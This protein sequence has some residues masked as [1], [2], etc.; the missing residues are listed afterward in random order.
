MFGTG[1]EA[2]VLL[3]TIKCPRY[4]VLI[5]L[6]VSMRTA[7]VVN[8]KSKSKKPGNGFEQNPFF[9]QYGCPRR[10]YL[11][12]ANIFCRLQEG[13]YLIELQATCYA[14]YRR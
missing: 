2:A 9:K 4:L 14:T 1:Q 5:L 12:F 8:S 7:K 10:G 11:G 3:G 6:V 13:C